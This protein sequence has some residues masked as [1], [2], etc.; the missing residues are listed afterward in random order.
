M[1]IESKYVYGGTTDV[2]KKDVNEDFLAFEILREDIL[3][4]VIADGAGSKQCGMALQ[5]A[6]I[7]AT[8]IIDTVKRIYNSNPALLVSNPTDV[9]S[10][11]MYVA[12][13][14]IGIFKVANPDLYSSFGVC[15]SCVLV[16]DNKFYLVHCGNTRIYM[17]RHLADGSARI[18]QLTQD[19]TKARERVQEGILNEAEYYSH[20]D[21]YTYTSGLGI[22]ADP[23]IQMYSGKFKQGDLLLMTTDG[24]HYAVRPE[25]ISQFVVESSTWEGAA[26]AL[27]E[28]AKFLKMDDN[29]TAAVIYSA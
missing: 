23:Q 14:T 4:G 20:P 5:P 17:I 28:A 22:V 3:V 27:I 8:E 9:L 16:I 21:R 10:E 25:Y 24:I 19:H 12:N 26:K 29:M 15:L 11:A 2:G 7:A 18:I 1:A 6:I 13:R